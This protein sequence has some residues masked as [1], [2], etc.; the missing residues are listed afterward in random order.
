MC[1]VSI[2]VVV[3]VYFRKHDSRRI[4]RAHITVTIEP[5]VLLRFGNVAREALKM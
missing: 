3:A 1:E 2:Y 4:V 5:N